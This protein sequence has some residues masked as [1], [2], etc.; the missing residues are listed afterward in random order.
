MGGKGARF[1]M[2][3]NILIAYL[4]WWF[5]GAFQLHHWYLGRDNQA[6]LGICLSP[7]FLVTLPVWWI[8]WVIDMFRIPSYVEQANRDMMYI[9]TAKEYIKNNKAPPFSI[10]R[11]LAQLLFS[12]YFFWVGSNLRFLLFFDVEMP[13]VDTA[14]GLV[15]CAIGATMVASCGDEETPFPH[16]LGCAIAGHF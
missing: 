4:S 15:G 10:R 2:E 12:N 3:S 7:F 16:V 1:S 13:I 6:L 11:M 9:N 8:A 5:G 14:F